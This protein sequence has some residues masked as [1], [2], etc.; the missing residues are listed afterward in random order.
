MSVQKCF[1]TTDIDEVGDASH[2][3]LFEMLGN[4][5]FGDYFK[6]GAIRFAWEFMTEV[7][8]LDP[9]RIW[10]TTHPDDIVG[11]D[12]WRDMIGLPESLQRAMAGRPVEIDGSRL[13]PEVQLLLR[14][15]YLTPER[16]LESLYQPE[17]RAERARAARA[18]EGR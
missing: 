15:Y 5:S 1:R 2:L 11:W 16:P 10:P 17:A 6:E 13:E 14:L 3:T 4:F 12:L 18:F 7:L 8:K 9:D